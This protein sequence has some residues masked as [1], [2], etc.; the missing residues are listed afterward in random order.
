MK[1]QTNEHNKVMLKLKEVTAEYKKQIRLLREIRKLKNLPTLWYNK[2]NGLIEVHF[3]NKTIIAEIIN[4][5]KETSRENS[6]NLAKGSHLKQIQYLTD[7][8]LN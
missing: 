6:D 3:E 1:T 4:I 5:D 2:E 7:E 8:D